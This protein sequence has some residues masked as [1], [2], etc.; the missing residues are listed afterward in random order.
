MA[1]AV[2]AITGMWARVFVV[3]Q[4][5]GDL[6]AGDLRQLNVHQDQVGHVLS[7]QRERGKALAGFQG[8]IALRLE[9]IMK[10]L[11]VQLVILDDED[12][13]RHPVPD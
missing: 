8:F 13:F 6:E 4:P 12:L 5:L 1:K 10:Q 3:L 11:H 7:R 9:Q 2:T